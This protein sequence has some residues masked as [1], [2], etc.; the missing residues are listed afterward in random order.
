GSILPFLLL[1][2]E[3]DL[4]SNLI[5]SHLAVGAD[6]PA[7]FLNLE[8]GEFFQRTLR[9]LQRHFYGRLDTPVCHPDYLNLLVYSLLAVHGKPPVEQRSDSCCKH[10]RVWTVCNSRAMWCAS[11]GIA[12]LH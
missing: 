6:V 12:K 9:F 5:F 11:P 3:G 1:Q 10:N 7:D 4:E 2:L 8:P